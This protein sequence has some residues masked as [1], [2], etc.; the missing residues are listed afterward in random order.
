MLNR[1]LFKS[2]VC[3]AL[4]LAL[5]ACAGLKERQ[6]TSFVNSLSWTNPMTGKRD[7]LRSS[8]PEKT[9]Q[10]QTESFPLAQLR[11]CDA[12]GAACAWGVMR[13]QRSVSRVDSVPGGISI[14]LV[15]V[16]DVDRRQEV[17]GPDSKVAMAMA[18]PA[19]VSAV[20]YKKEIRQRFILPYG[21]VQHVELDYGLSFE[22]CALR[23]DA[24]GRA[25]DVCEIPYI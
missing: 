21:K 13:A 16:I 4:V 8:W 15:L 9:L 12:A 22:L 17:H 19:D 10:G 14:D 24:A 7:G 3:L 20:R 25:L 6:Y 5:S 2:A 23:Y 18:I 11:Q 1:R